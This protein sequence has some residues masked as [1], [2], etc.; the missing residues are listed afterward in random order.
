MQL[1]PKSQHPNIPGG[2]FWGNTA[3]WWEWRIFDL[4]KVVQIMKLINL[5][6]YFRIGG[7]YKEFCKTQEINSESEVV[8]IYAQMPVK[9]DS[10]L[11]FFPIEETEGRIEYLA[12]GLQYQNLF[13]FFYFLDVM[14]DVNGNNLL[15]DCD[16]AQTLFSFA[17][18]DA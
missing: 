4:G 11:G 3:S 15:S 6:S 17:L 7:T 9:L 14:K 8:E 2:N 5:V 12:E 16:I 10:Q 13:D 18:N 1:V